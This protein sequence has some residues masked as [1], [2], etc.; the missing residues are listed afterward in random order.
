MNPEVF[1]NNT[2]LSGQPLCLAGLPLLRLS[3]AEYNSFTSW[4]MLL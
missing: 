1:L 3:L 2:A 4:E